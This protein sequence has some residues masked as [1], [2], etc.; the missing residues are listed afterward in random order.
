MYSVG[1]TDKSTHL[2]TDDDRR[3]RRRRRRRSGSGSSSSSSS[4]KH[5]TRWESEEGKVGEN[6]VSRRRDR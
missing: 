3:R 2:R 6:R 4:K 5:Y 1:L